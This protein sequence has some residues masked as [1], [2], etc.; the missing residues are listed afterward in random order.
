MH[1]ITCSEYCRLLEKKH[2]VQTKGGTMIQPPQ[3][4]QSERQPLNR[5]ALYI[6]PLLELDGEY[7]Y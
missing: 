3:S 1:D 2:T 5:Q 7:Q 4:M 6:R